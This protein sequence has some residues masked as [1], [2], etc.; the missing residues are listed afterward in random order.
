MKGVAYKLPIPMARAQGTTNADRPACAM[1]AAYASVLR[2]DPLLGVLRGKTDADAICTMQAAMLTEFDVS[3]QRLATWSDAINGAKITG[4][5]PTT[6]GGMTMEPYQL[7]AVKALS[8]AGGVL[9]L[10]CGLGKTL[11]ACAFAHAI[12]AQRIVILCPLNAIPVWKRY[13]PL[14]PV[15]PIIQSMDS[16]H[17]LKG[18]QPVDLIIFD[19]AHLQGHQSAKR[20]KD[21][22]TLRLKATA[23]LCLTGTLL[24]AGIV[25]S[26]S[27]LDLAI[28]GAAGFSNRWS[29]GEHFR[30]LIRKAIGGRT[31]TEV[32][33]PPLN[34]RAQYHEYLARHTIALTPSSAAVR[35]VLQLPG[36]DV[37][38]VPLGE[39]WLPLEQLAAD[40]V[41]AAIN[42]GEPIPS[43]ASTAHALCQAGADTKTD[44]VMQ[45]LGSDPCVIFA[46][47]TATLDTMAAK[48]TA[49]GISFVRVDGAVVGADRAAAQTA[50]QS[51]AV[52]V[53]LG[54]M[55]AAGISMDLFRSPYSI[56]LDHPWKAADYAQALA[57]T[58]R[59]GQI[60]KCTHWDLFTNSLQ[61]RVVQRLRNGE[62]FNAE[63][64]EWQAVK[65]SVDKQSLA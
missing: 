3:P 38:D 20:T 19:E 14:L 43:A 31:V 58:H 33:Q 41:H 32:G 36:Q 29:A 34:M 57:R 17:H 28:P 27:V 45:N 39:P 49:A 23:G 21:A 40:H 54:Q 63:T 30:C 52:Q 51:G 62:A 44:W 12:A 15:P 18:M 16:A 50:F 60:Q 48:L 56:A 64:A 7:D 25:K 4:P 42:S 61:R 22:H 9:A 1:V 5:V 65:A 59:R 10:G 37:H 8:P 46:H 53:F 35:A 13:A 6:L 24:H 26:L 11:A 2:N 55:S 47:Y